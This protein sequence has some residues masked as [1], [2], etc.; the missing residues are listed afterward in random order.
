M[1]VRHMKRR[2]IRTIAR[3]RKRA[4]PGGGMR[5]GS[6]PRPDFRSPSSHR[7]SGIVRH[8]GDQMPSRQLFDSSRFDRDHLTASGRRAAPR[9]TRCSPRNVCFRLA[10]R[11]FASRSRRS[12]EG[13]WPR[14]RA[15][16]SNPSAKLAPHRSSLAVYGRSR[17]GHP[18][19]FYPFERAVLRSTTSVSRR[20]SSDGEVPLSPPRVFVWS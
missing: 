11:S 19:P 17:Q 14:T 6:F 10:A 3:R 18:H 16:S 20:P 7:A 1:W 15:A 9:A 2:D 8:G 4:A 12:I 5:R 13:V